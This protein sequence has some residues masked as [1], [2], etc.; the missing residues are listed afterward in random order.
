L[1]AVTQAESALLLM[2]GQPAY[3]ARHGW[4]VHVLSS[5]GPDLDVVANREGVA[6]HPVRMER[7]IRPIQD[8]ISLALVSQMM[9]RL[10]PEVVNAGTPKAALLA[11]IA[12]RVLGVPVRIYTLRGLRLETEA[13]WRRAILWAMEWLTSLCAQRIICVSRS[14][15]RRYLEEGLADGTKT[16]VLGEGSSNGVEVER[17]DLRENRAA[18]KVRLGLQ[19]ETPTV[20]FVG[21]LHKDKGVMDLIPVMRK[22]REKVSGAHLVVVGPDEGTRLCEGTAP[23]WLVSLGRV[24]DTSHIYGAMDVLLFPS[25]RE[26]FPNVLLEA[27]AAGVPTVGYRVTGVVDAVVD[28]MTGTLVEID[29]RD[30]LARA[31]ARYLLDDALRADHGEAARK[32]VAASFSREDLWKR[33]ATE[34]LRLLENV[35]GRRN[36]AGGRPPCGS[37][38]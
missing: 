17:F 1:L 34:Y 21:R 9:W 30:E 13:G 28:G 22:V 11:L 23:Q 35:G 19:P 32:R 25:R 26:G 5:P 20:G 3:F 38:R 8:L 6:V 12:G 4:E 36:S 7:G 27:A 33:L 15:Q 29:D 14:L 31:V 18:S 24:E 10:R 16:V 37:G 2:R